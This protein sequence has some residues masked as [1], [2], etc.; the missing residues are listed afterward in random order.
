MAKTIGEIIRELR[1]QQKITQEE[2][3]EQIGVTPQAISRWE[4][5]V[6]YP[7]ITQIVPLSKALGVSTDEILGANVGTVEEQIKEY[8]DLSLKA[9]MEGD[10]EKSIEILKE[11]K[12]RFPKSYLIS[13]KLASALASHNSKNMLS[14]GFGR[15]CVNSMMGIKLRGNGLLRPADGILDDLEINALAISDEEKTAIMISLDTCGI[16]WECVKEF[17]K[18]IF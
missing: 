5:D 8:I 10:Y 15:V 1:K 2:L 13:L 4:R 16:E 18:S 17:K 14:A 12:A 9:S 3:A 7:D 6:G 11:A